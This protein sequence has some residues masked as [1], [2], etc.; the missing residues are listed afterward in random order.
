MGRDDSWGTSQET[1]EPSIHKLEREDEEVVFWG[2]PYRQANSR[3]FI[4][5]VWSSWESLISVFGRAVGSFSP[6]WTEMIRFTKHYGMLRALAKVWDAGP[7]SDWKVRTLK[8]EMVSLKKRSETVCD[9]LV[10]GKASTHPEDDFQTKSYLEHLTG[11]VGEVE[12]PVWPREGSPDL[13]TV[14]RKIPMPGSSKFYKKQW[15]F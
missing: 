2:G 6:A 4:Q 3:S 11:H 15:Y 1:G 7:L 5:S 13:I 14:E 10:V 12:L 9:L 8:W